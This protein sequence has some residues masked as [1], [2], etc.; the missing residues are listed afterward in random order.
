MSVPVSVPASFSP[1]SIFNQSTFHNKTAMG[2]KMQ[3]SI[4]LIGNDTFVNEQLKVAYTLI[5]R[6]STIVNVA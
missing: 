6:G 2:A 5:I 3:A 4:F 1:L